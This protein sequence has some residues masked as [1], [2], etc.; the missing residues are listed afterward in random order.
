MSS[1]KLPS[2]EKSKINF[3]IRSVNH[4]WLIGSLSQYKAD[5]LILEQVLQHNQ[6]KPTAQGKSELIIALCLIAI[7]VPYYSF[8]PQPSTFTFVCSLSSFSSFIL[9]FCFVIY[10]ANKDL[11]E[12]ISLISSVKIA[13][14][15]P[16]LL[17]VD[18][19]VYPGYQII[20]FGFY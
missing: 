16:S 20:L 18:G 13:I 6:R 15:P 12:S 14:C 1:Q 10:V 9:Q 11:C 8:S 17:L 5:I 4:T 19:F 3:S 2:Q 7:S